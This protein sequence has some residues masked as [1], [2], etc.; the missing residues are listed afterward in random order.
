M[1]YFLFIVC[2]SYLSFV[3]LICRL[4]FLFVV[5]TSYLCTYF[6]FF[7]IIVLFIY[8]LYFLYVVLLMYR[9]LLTIFKFKDYNLRLFNIFFKSR[10][11]SA[12]IK[13]KRDV[14]GT[15]LAKV[16]TSSIPYKLVIDI[17]GNVILRLEIRITD[18]RIMM[19]SINNDLSLS[20]FLPPFLPSFLPPFLPS[21]LPPFLPSSLP[22]FL[23]SSLPPFLPSSLPPFLP[24]SLPPFLS[25]P[26]IFNS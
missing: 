8:R 20:L 24:S 4:Y 7:L 25:S 5:C 3:L 26:F 2:T 12:W 6:F 13:P 16:T 19:V 17:K 10:L 21:S 15:I 23:P 1:S 9:L 18:P 11:R 14:I 22:P